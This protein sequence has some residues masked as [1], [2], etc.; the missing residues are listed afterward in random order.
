LDSHALAVLG[1]VGIAVLGVDAPVVLHV[2]E[3]QVH[4]APEA[5]VV[6][7]QIVCTF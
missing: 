6:P 7:L 5:A 1:G 2:L 3:G 4:E